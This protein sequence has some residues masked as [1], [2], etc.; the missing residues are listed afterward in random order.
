MKKLVLII[1]FFT[2][3]NLCISQTIDLFFEQTNEFL[4]KN[5]TEDGKVDYAKLKKSPGELMYILKNIENLKTTFTDKDISKAFWINVY[6]LEVIKGVLDNYPLKSVNSIEGFFKENNFMVANQELT[7]DDVENTILREI[8]IDPGI[9]FVLSSAANGGAP[10]LNAAYLPETVASQMKD[11]AK[12]FVNNKN[13]VRLD[14]NSK[15]VELPKIFEWYK[16]DFVT[17]Y[18][19]EIDFVNI[20]IDKKLDNKYAV[21]TYD[22]DWSLNQK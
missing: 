19:N 2:F 20:F 16:K 15:T 1:L 6:N 9:H 5:V 17:N 12:L 10:L 13:F 21:K 18:F 8:F 3:S 7:L 4:I 11:R 22:F 14:K